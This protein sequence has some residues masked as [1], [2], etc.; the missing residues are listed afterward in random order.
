MRQKAHGQVRRSQVI[1]TYGPGALIDL[2]QESAIVAGL[3]EWPPAHRLEE[4]DEPRLARKLQAIT[5]VATPQLLAPPPAS[6]DPGARPTGI[7]AWRFPEWFV[8]QAADVGEGAAQTRS[9]RLVH[10]KALD[11]KRRFEGRDVVATRFVRGCPR[12][13]VDDLDWR[14]FVH[15]PGNECPPTR[16]LWLDEQGTT[17]DLTD[18]MVRCECGATRRLSD[19]SMIE[20]NPLG[21]CRGARPWLGRDTNEECNL[22]SRLLV[23]TASNAWFPQVLSVLSIPER[24][25]A[26]ETAVR[27]RNRSRG[28]RQGLTDMPDEVAAQEARPIL[29]VILA[30]PRGFC[31]GVERAIDTVEAALQKYGAPVYVRHEIVHNRRVVENLKAKG[32]RFVDHVEEIPR[33]M[34]AV[35]SAHGVSA[36]V[37]QDAMAQGLRPIDATCPLVSKV[38]AEGRRYAADG[39]DIVLI[40]HENHPEVEGTV[41]QIPGRVLV[42]GDV[43]D[44]GALRVRDPERVAYIT[45][46]TLSVDDTREVIAALRW[47]F[48]KIVGPDVKDICYATQNRQSAVRSAA[49]I[50]DLVLVSGRSE[51]LQREPATRSG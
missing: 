3:D 29:R 2:P 14:R 23:R 50:V 11:Q 31:A 4:I 35:F 1:T 44:V 22:P 10:R 20:I 13:H 15:R 7:G 46:T 27:V 9:R 39:Y 43:E 45:Q 51:Q 48:P 19:A 47:R 16:P 25:A 36:K 40:G 8:V 41:G 37:E 5:G 34:V 21:T 30:Q 28:T 26:V 38:H 33:R 18:L 42:V 32:V 12:G 6:S 17:G 49:S 24:G